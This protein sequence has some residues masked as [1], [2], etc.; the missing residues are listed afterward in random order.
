MALGKR[1]QDVY[2]DLGEEKRFYKL[3]EAIAGIKR[4]AKCKFDESVD[5]ALVLNVDMRKTDQHIRGVFQPPHGLGKQ[6][7]VLVFASPDK[8]AEAKSS[9]ADIVGGEDLVDKILSEGKVDVDVCVATPDMMMHVGKLGR[10]LGSRGLLPNPKL[11]TVS[12][13]VARVVKEAKGGR[14]EYR[15]DR[16]G[17]MRVALGKASFAEN[18]L[19]ENIVEFIKTIV[20]ARPSGVK[21]VLLKKVFVGSTMGPAFELDLKLLS[22]EGISC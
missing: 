3:S 10:L 8:E 5:C 12:N 11:G 2:K 18:A 20:Q 4:Y 1:L 16:A 9:G 14:V 15:A 22:E 17:V 7:R 19:K 6:V 13:D 21:G